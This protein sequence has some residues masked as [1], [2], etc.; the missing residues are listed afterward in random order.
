MT[1]IDKNFLYHMT[2]ADLKKFFMYLMRIENYTRAMNPHLLNE[3]YLT[4]PEILRLINYCKVAHANK[5]LNLYEFKT[6]NLHD[7][8]NFNGFLH[9]RTAQEISKYMYNPA[10][11]CCYDYRDDPEAMMSN[12]IFKCQF[13]KQIIENIHDAP[14][15]DDDE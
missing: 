1:H 10:E 12:D 9:T 7:P 4:K 5:N 11:E 14:W 13:D 8:D 3:K 6:I 15:F 2:Y